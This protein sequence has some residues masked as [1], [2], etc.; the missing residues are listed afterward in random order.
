M[1]AIFQA[2]WP[3]QAPFAPWSP[4]AT[5]PGLAWMGSLGER[6]FGCGRWAGALTESPHS[7]VRSLTRAPLARSVLLRPFYAQIATP[8]YQGPS[9][10]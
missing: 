7:Y 4:A 5:L 3:A 9:Y 2:A 10:S 1:R 8:A 6:A